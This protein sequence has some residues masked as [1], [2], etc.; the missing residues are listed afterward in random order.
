M[1]STD[2]GV[3]L[4]L[5]KNQLFNLVQLLNTPPSG[6]S[7]RLYG[8]VIDLGVS[9]H[10][11]CPFDLLFDVSFISH[12]LI[13]IHNVDVVTANHQGNL[14][15]GSAII[16]YSVYFVPELTNTLI[17]LAQRSKDKPYF[18]VFIENFV[19]CS[20]TR[21][22]IETKMSAVEYTI[23][24]KCLLFGPLLWNRL[25]VVNCDALNHIHANLFDYMDNQQNT[26]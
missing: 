24:E 26:Q 17:S 15:L 7:D 23:F 19:I 8:I 11:T 22:L 21:T 2:Y 5:S 18:T 14:L 10:L 16:L 6:V 9:H 3:G 13:N 20:I 25:V 12:C 4:T 1:I